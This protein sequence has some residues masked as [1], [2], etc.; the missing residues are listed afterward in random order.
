MDGEEK[1][2]DEEAPTPEEDNFPAAESE[3]VQVETEPETVTVEGESEGTS[4][5]VSKETTEQPTEGEED[6]EVQAEAEVAEE[7]PHSVKLDDGT[8]VSI[9]EDLEGAAL[10]AEL[11]ED[12]KEVYLDAIGEA[13]N[14]PVV[15]S[16]SVEGA[17]K[18]QLTLENEQFGDGTSVMSFVGDDSDPVPLKTESADGQLRVEAKLPA[19]LVA[20]N[21]EKADDVTEPEAA[22]DVTKSAPTEEGTVDGEKAPVVDAPADEDVD[23]TTDEAGLAE[24]EATAETNK[25]A[26]KEPDADETPVDKTPEVTEP[27][28]ETKVDET[29]EVTEPVDETK[30]DETPVVKEP[31]GEDKQADKAEKKE[32]KLSK[33][34]ISFNDKKVTIMGILPESGSVEVRSVEVN[35]EE[36]VL[37]GTKGS[38]GTNDTKSNETQEID[39]ASFDITI[40][41]VNGDEWQPEKGESVEVTIT[42]ESFGNDKVLTVYH[43]G[44]TGREFVAEV[45]SRDNTITFL[46]EH[47]SIYVV[48]DPGQTGED[49][50]LTVNFYR[51]TTLIKAEMITA[52]QYDA[53][54]INTYI[55]DP[56]AGDTSG[57]IFKGWT[58]DPNYGTDTTPK[59]IDEVRTAVGALLTA[60]VTEGQSTDYYAMLFKP[61]YVTYRDEKGVIITS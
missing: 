42:D 15:M 46:A 45:T 22:E 54:Q 25:P 6:E 16:V 27:V 9:P 11:V 61:Y 26:E 55:Y 49:A 10:S 38:K 13:V 36:L 56:G 14:E 28:V 1:D 33:Q 52:R 32:V 39:L 18:A 41:D 21:V 3:I 24:G 5:E 59:T 30:V 29:P 37:R 48:V 8:V 17:D 50:R 34:P 12:N 4:E 43:E 7:A 40:K 57:L 31:V 60:G 19:V 51:G 47:F 58:D 23:K 44:E 20:G 53:N 35:K 2:E